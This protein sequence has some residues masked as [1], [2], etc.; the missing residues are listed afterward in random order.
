[1]SNLKHVFYLNRNASL[2]PQVVRMQL[3][4]NISEMWV[5]PFVT[6]V[7]KILVRQQFPTAHPACNAKHSW[8]NNMLLCCMLLQQHSAAQH[9]ASICMDSLWQRKLCWDF[10]SAHCSG[11]QRKRTTHYKHKTFQQLANRI[12]TLTSI[13]RSCL[14]FWCPPSHCKS[15]YPLYVFLCP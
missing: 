12:N 9:G 3:S 13:Y 11:V 7:N 4:Q 5:H 1:M 15:Q 2:L 6:A 8:L 10:P 14:P